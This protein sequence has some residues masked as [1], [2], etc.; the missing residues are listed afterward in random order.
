MA[1]GYTLR[2]N[3]VFVATSEALYQSCRFPHRADVQKMILSERSPMTAKMRSKPYR[4]DTRLDWDYV[5]VHVMRWCLRVK[6]YQNRER[7]S[8]LLHETDSKMIV[9]ESRRD[10]YWGAKPTTDNALVG[11]NVL[12]RLLAE[13]RDL[14]VNAEPPK[15]LSVAPPGIPDFLFLDEPIDVARLEREHALEERLLS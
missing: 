7:F 4:A 11:C 15:Q 3:G 14:Y 5:R 8:R 2:I 13:L 9:E 12:G 1:P 10:A 6:L